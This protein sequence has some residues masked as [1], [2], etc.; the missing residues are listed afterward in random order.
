MRYCDHCKAARTKQMLEFDTFC[1]FC[2]SNT[3]QMRGEHLGEATNLQATAT[4]Y[5]HPGIFSLNMPGGVPTI[6][7]AN[8]INR[9]VSEVEQ[10]TGQHVASMEH[11]EGY[12]YD[13]KLSAN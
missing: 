2:G 7:N 3:V 12:R 6:L 11:I 1:A 8:D 9:A 5:A 13:L 4:L 10:L